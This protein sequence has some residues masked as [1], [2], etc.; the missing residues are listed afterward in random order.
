MKAAGNL[1][2]RFCICQLNFAETP[3]RRSNLGIL[4]LMQKCTNTTDLKPAA[5][6]KYRRCR[7]YRQAGHPGFRCLIVLRHYKQMALKAMKAY[8]LVYCAMQY[9]TSGKLR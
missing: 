7:R 5:L 2:Q 3:S 9:T 4:A 1:Q 8:V 6:S